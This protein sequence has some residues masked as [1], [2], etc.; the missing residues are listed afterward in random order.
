MLGAATAST[1]T[2]IPVAPDELSSLTPA[3]MRVNAGSCAAP[4]ATTLIAVS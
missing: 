1:T 2:V 4:S 3:A